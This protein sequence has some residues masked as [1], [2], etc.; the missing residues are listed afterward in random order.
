M[1]FRISNTLGPM[2]GLVGLIVAGHG[3]AARASESDA[4]ASTSPSAVYVLEPD[5][6]RLYAVVRYERGLLAGALGHDHVIVATGWRGTVD[7][8]PTRSERCRIDVAVPVSGLLVDPG[9][10]RAWEGLDGSTSDGDKSTITSN[11]R[12]SKQLDMGAHPQIRFSSR[13]CDPDGTVV[14]SLSIRGVAVEVTIPMQIEADADG[15]RARGRFSMLHSDFGFQP[16]RALAGALRNQDRL[17]LVV[18][19]RGAPPA[20]PHSNP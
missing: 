9:A 1:E 7:W 12:G 6:S 3:M 11:L 8:D 15:I 13:Q 17:E 18:D 5:S 2:M 4:A 10:S 16:F 20:I 14:G 19:V